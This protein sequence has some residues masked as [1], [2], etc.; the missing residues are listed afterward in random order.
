MAD[1]KFNAALASAYSRKAKV[2]IKIVDMKDY[3]DNASNAFDFQ[4]Q[5]DE[6]TGAYFPSSDS[7]RDFDG[8][9]SIR[10]RVPAKGAKPEGITDVL[11]H[12]LV[13]H[14]TTSNGARLPFAND[15]VDNF[16]TA[17]PQPG[18]FNNLLNDSR[19]NA[20]PVND[21]NWLQAKR[22]GAYNLEL[23]AYM[24]V[25]N[26]RELPQVTKYQRDVYMQDLMDWLKKTK[27]GSVASKLQELIQSRDAYQ[28]T[29]LFPNKNIG[30]K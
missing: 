24:S 1:K 2:P 27:Q 26:Q 30:E 14:L 11:K 7:S 23:P 16:K 13:H 25:Y 10:I 21:Y 6:A 22:G 29:G 9:D 3:M 5:N 18:F 8:L 17:A 19:G 28:G 15:M 12:E 20:S 4:P